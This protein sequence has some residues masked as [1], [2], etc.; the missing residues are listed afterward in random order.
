MPQHFQR[1]AALSQCFLKRRQPFEKPC[2]L[3]RNH[4]RQVHLCSTQCTHK[5]MLHKILERREFCADD[6]LKKGAR[7]WGPL[8]QLVDTNR[9]TGPWPRR[10]GWVWLTEGLLVVGGICVKKDLAV[11]VVGGGRYPNGWP[12]LSHKRCPQEAREEGGSLGILRP[13]PAT[14][15]VA[16]P[17]LA[18]AVV[19]LTSPR[20]AALHTQGSPNGKKHISRPITGQSKSGTPPFERV[21]RAR[22]ESTVRMPFWHGIPWA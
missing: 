8:L 12:P 20:G 14:A 2:S 4:L 6:C 1:K 3:K 21:Q 22:K 19:L 13:L 16:S 17:A 11:V 18:K 9:Q 7:R 15:H 5:V 10:R